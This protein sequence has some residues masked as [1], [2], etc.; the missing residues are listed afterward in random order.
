MS[1]G[2]TD[3]QREILLTWHENPNA[4][5][6]EIATACDCSSSYVS[7]VKNRFDGYNEMEAMFDRQDRELE[8]MFGS[9]LFEGSSQSVQETASTRNL[10]NEPGIAEMYDELPNNAAGNII[11]AIM[12]LVLLYVL[13]EIVMVLVL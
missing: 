5:N 4:T 3:L 7:Q 6:A 11:R 13:Y 10:N 12:L 8:R 9:G 2:K 1:D